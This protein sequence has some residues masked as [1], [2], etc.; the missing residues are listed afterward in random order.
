ME[1]ACLVTVAQIMF[2]P[3]QQEIEELKTKILN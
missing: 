3:T 2:I 1:E